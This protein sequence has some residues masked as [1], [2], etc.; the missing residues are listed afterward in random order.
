MEWIIIVHVDCLIIL[1]FPKNTGALL[2]LLVLRIYLLPIF[3]GSQMTMF[4]NLLQLT[5]SIYLKI[6]L[7]CIMKDILHHYGRKGIYK[8]KYVQHIYDSIMYSCKPSKMRH[9]TLNSDMKE[10]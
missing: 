6:Y 5:P 4:A 9:A 8:P 3:A 7:S 10:G 2:Y 1:E